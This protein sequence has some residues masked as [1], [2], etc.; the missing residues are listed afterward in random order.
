[1]RGRLIILSVIAALFCPSQCQKRSPCFHIVLD[2]RTWLGTVQ[3][4]KTTM[5]DFDSVKGHSEKPSI[6]ST[7]KAEE[8]ES[9]EKLLR[10]VAC[11]GKLARWDYKFK[12]LLTTSNKKVQLSNLG[13][14]IRYRSIMFQS[15][16]KSKKKLKAK[17]PYNGQGVLTFNN[18][19]TRGASDYREGMKNGKCFRVHEQLQKIS[20]TFHQDLP[21]VRIDVLVWFW[22][23]F[24]GESHGFFGQG[25]IQVH[26]FSGASQVV[27]VRDGQMIGATKVFDKSRRLQYVKNIQTGSK[28]MEVNQVNANLTHFSGGVVMNA[29]DD[30]IYHCEQVD[31]FK[32]Q[33]CRFLDNAYIRTTFDGARGFDFKLESMEG[34][35]GSSFTLN[36][37]TL[38]KHFEADAE[39]YPFCPNSESWNSDS[40]PAV[41]SNWIKSYR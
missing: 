18:P 10:K 3:N 15:L 36:T 32:N 40:I 20:G 14:P 5:F 25:P 8:E 30:E 22:W 26:Y 39:L 23:I 33:G 19:R 6:C 4:D 29:R 16:D 24:M 12:V 9:C 38:N 31:R 13:K 2:F 17:D 7:K 1:M 21:T 28:T 34:K 37:V 41:L 35:G 11:D 27:T